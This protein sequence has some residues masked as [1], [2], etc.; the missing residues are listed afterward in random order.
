VIGKGRVE[1]FSDGVIAV[2]ITLLVLDLH[3][4]DPDR[5]HSLAHQLGEQWPSY[6]AYVVSFLTIGIIWI[7]HH[8]MLR[9]IVGVD[10]SVLTFNIILLMC[11]VAVPFTTALMAEYLDADNGARTAA[12][13]YGGSLFVMGLV[14][15][16]MQWHLMTRRAN[17]LDERISPDARTAIV[18]RNAFG[19]A[20]YLV[21]T[22][23]G[24]WT[25]YLTVAICGAVAVFYAL[26]ST[27]SDT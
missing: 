20:P 22:V 7:N 10:H 24:L 8:A 2:A 16:L 18:R 12:V 9:R 19:V 17:L 11:I 6:V 26:P 23:A 4:P 5:E 25:P 3:V 21:A 13:I 14:F 1:A 15:F 27:T